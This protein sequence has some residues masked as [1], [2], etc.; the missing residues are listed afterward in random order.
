MLKAHYS[1]SEKSVLTVEPC[2]KV[3]IMQLSQTCAW[4]SE[5]LTFKNSSHIEIELAPNTF[6]G[7]D[8]VLQMHREGTKKKSKRLMTLLKLGQSCV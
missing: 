4:S 8:F 2:P 7:N 1:D 6:E 3:F 5:S